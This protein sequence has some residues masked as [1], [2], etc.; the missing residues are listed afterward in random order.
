[1][2]LTSLLWV[3]FMCPR[4]SFHFL[5]IPTCCNNNL[6]WH[7]SMGYLHILNFDLWS[8]VERASY[9]YHHY[10]LLLL[11]QSCDILS[12]STRSS[13]QN[14]V[15]VTLGRWR[16]VSWIVWWPL[17]SRAN[18]ILKENAGNVASP[19]VCSNWSI[20]S[21]LRMWPWVFFYLSSIYLH[22]YRNRQEIPPR[23]GGEHH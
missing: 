21:W 11:K 6:L 22:C 9:Y 7:L 20:V 17:T 23:S 8:D 3:S 15:Q 16:G 10:Y 12:C 2:L 4:W 5:L 14:V 1:M 18:T 13:S 19:T